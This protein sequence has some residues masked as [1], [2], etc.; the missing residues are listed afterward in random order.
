MVDRGKIGAV[1]ELLEHGADVTG[2]HPDGRSL[3]QLA[4][5]KGSEEIMNL[6]E[7]YGAKA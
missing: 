7:E 3:A 1:R 2:R 5:D 4:R 6:L